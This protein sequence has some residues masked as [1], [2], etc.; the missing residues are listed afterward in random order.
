M[1]E[2]LDGAIGVASIVE[3]LEQDAICADVLKHCKTSLLKPLYDLLLLCWE[4]GN[5]PQDFKTQK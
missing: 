5:V 2:E 1:I 3:Y 4:A